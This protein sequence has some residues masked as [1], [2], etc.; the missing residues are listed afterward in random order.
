MP[1]THDKRDGVTTAFTKLRYANQ[2][3]DGYVQI[4]GNI[5][6]SLPGHNP[7][8]IA[9]AITSLESGW[10]D[11]LGLG[12]FVMPDGYSLASLDVYFWPQMEAE[13]TSTNQ[14]GS[15]VGLIGVP[16]SYGT[17]AVWD[18]LLIVTAAGEGSCWAA[19]RED[20]SI[21][22]GQMFMAT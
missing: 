9:G 18:T 19:Y 7:Q 22:A 14:S 8:I 11:L 10:N 17:T 6:S 15:W 12:I 20:C 2:N 4:N 3:G 21:G 13:P 16:P 5:N 1:N